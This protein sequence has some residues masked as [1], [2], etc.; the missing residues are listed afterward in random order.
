MNEQVMRL[1]ACLA[2]LLLIEDE[3]R[4]GI[5]KVNRKT[6]HERIVEIGEANFEAEVLKSARPVL[7]AFCSSW[8]RPC[9]IIGR[10]LDEV[11][12]MGAGRWKVVKVNAD[13]HPALSLAYEVQSIPTLL[14]FAGGTLRAR[15]VGTV[16][17]EAVL[18]QMQTTSRAADSTPPSL[19]N[20]AN[21]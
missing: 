8:S 18:S 15:T 21:R 11:V 3:I 9:R 19:H 10:V 7:V 17:K 2:P 12:T 1:S 4:N 14:Y 13:N 16:S 6:V 20:P 5:K